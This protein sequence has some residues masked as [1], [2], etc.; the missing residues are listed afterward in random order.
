MLGALAGKPNVLLD[1]WAYFTPDA[2]LVGQA[3]RQITTLQISVC[4]SPSELV[5][6]L[7]MV[8]VQVAAVLVT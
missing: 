5:V 7:A 2:A 1:C 4:A 8:M 6:Y 3:R